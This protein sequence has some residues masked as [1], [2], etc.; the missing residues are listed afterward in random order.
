MSSS[1]LDFESSQ[2]DSKLR[3]VHVS[4]LQNLFYLIFLHLFEEKKIN[5]HS[6]NSHHLRQ[7]ELEDNLNELF[8]GV[9]EDAELQK[10]RPYKIIKPDPGMY[11]LFFFPF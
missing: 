11:F 1:Y 6:L 7:N 4:F 5:V 8:G 3:V 9:K 2:I 10:S